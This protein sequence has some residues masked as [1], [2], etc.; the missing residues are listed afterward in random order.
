[1]TNSKRDKKVKTASAFV[2]YAGMGFQMLVV[3]GV[4]TFVGHKI[5]GKSK[6]PIFTAV[7]GL[8][9]V[10]LSL[11]QVIRSLSKNKA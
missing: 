8:I 9:G 6:T 7:F 11:Y 5:D 1:M 2:Q 4:F 3:I 10:V